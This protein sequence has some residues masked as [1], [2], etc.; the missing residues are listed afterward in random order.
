MKILK[1]HLM[2]FG[3]FEGVSIDLERGN[4]GLHIIYGPNEAGKSSALRALRQ[5][6][7]GIPIRSTDNFRHPHHQMRIGASIRHSD[8]DVLAFVRR[9][10]NSNT[11]RAADDDTI[12]DDQ[13]LSR[14]L[15]GIDAELFSTMFGIDHGDLVRGGRE[16]IQGGGNLGQIIFA[17]GSGVT[18]LRNVQAEL[19]EKADA[20]FKPTGKLPRINE[21]ILRIKENRK[22]LRDAQLSSGDWVLHDKALQAATESKNR[23]EIQLTDARSEKN[24]LERSREALPLI[25]NR[26]EIMEGLKQYWSAVLLPDNFGKQRREYISNLKIAQND[27][28]QAVENIKQLQNEIDRLQVSERILEKTDAIENIYQ[29]LGGYAKAASDRIQL[30]ARRD[31]LRSEAKQILLD[32]RNDLTID[33]ADRL[34]LSKKDTLHIQELGS[35]YE[36]IVTLI[37]STREDIPRFEHQIKEIDN[38][39]SVLKMP[40]PT[41]ELFDAMERASEYVSIEKQC[42]DELAEYTHAEKSLEIELGRQSLWSGTLADLERLAIPAAETIEVFE[43]DFA[44]VGTSIQALENEIKKLAADL[45]GTIKRIDEL[46]LNFSIPTESDLL[47]ARENRNERWRLIARALNASLETGQKT[48]DILKDFSDARD[49]CAAFE[50]SMGQADE[51]SDRLRH[52]A[53]RVA[54][55]AKLI[56]DKSETEKNLTILKDELKER[57]LQHEEIGLKWCRLWSSAGITPASPKEM[58]V[59]TLR[60]QD[61]TARFADIRKRKSRTEAQ[62]K[63]ID[64]LRH[65]ILQTLASMSEPVSGMDETLNDLSKKGRQ[66]IEMEQRLSGQRE[67][68]ENEKSQK[69][70]LLDELKIRAKVNE[71]ELV[72]WQQKWEQAVAPIGLGAD[73][74]PAHAGALMEE[75]KMLFDKLKEADVIQKRINGI[76]RDAALFQTR[77]AEQVN[78]VASDLAGQPAD[79][80]TVEINRR[81]KEAQTAYSKKQTL[82]NQIDKENHRI[83][84]SSKT[85]ADVE[86][87]L[88]TMCEESGCKDYRELP[89]AE[90]RSAKRRELESDLKAVDVQLIKLSA[91]AAIEDFVIECLSIE[92]D[93]IGSKIEILSENIDQLTKGKSDLDQTIGAERTELGKM[94]GSAL[95]AALAEETQALLGGLEEN[96][97]DFARL[98][99]SSAILNQ[100]IERFR[101]KHQSPVLLKAGYFFSQITDG[102]FEGIRAE[103]DDSG[104]PVIAGI[105]KAGKEIVGVDGMSE[106]TADQLFLSLRLAGLDEYL[107][108][109]EPMPFIVDDILIK[110]DDSRAIAALK[111]LAELSAKTQ[112][113]FFT[114]HRHLLELAEKYIDPLVLVCHSLN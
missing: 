5:V 66:I 37:E 78:D 36:R 74:V 97:E 46:T 108:K 48:D 52:E 20:L 90:L 25:A 17:A 31:L 92:P 8:G 84:L 29:D 79:K 80:A 60:K 98:K 18:R 54:F 38:R 9:K 6:F 15:K 68:L 24:R 94:D 26:R 40:R 70:A 55:L 67:K 103:F 88:K 2:A 14:F 62:K 4:H 105:R 65:T 30:E 112:I 87:L 57:N 53:D 72:L 91:G 71:K 51:I 76:D 50:N 81:L 63:R 110:F 23:I 73:S 100:A 75:L 44:A 28:S 13:A 19:Q 43:S 7:F 102:S 27:Q 111:A 104:S 96:I 82:K 109:N 83:R 59:W 69:A 113:I 35:R 64:H 56:S 99:I 47:S 42:I 41:G 49:L 21:S 12:L 10:G 95:A 22:K 32:L 11:L 85:I 93:S 61:I 45:S 77:V 1:L 16:I 86:T 58:R 89:E 39:L 107:D 34:R 114:H 33:D 3:P 106:G 101:D